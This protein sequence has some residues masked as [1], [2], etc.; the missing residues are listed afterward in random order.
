MVI[1]HVD[2]TADNAKDL[3]SKYEVRGYPTLSY[4]ADGDTAGQP[5]NGGRDLDTLKTFVKVR[6]PYE[7]ENP[8]VTTG[9]EACEARATVRR[10][11][12]RLMLRVAPTSKVTLISEFTVC[13]L[14]LESTLQP[15]KS[16]S[17]SPTP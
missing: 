2:C 14:G 9:R 15:L 5:Y 1:G 11:C 7:N 17:S 3:C 8:F 16:P 13:D 6:C 10:V 4:F 12:A